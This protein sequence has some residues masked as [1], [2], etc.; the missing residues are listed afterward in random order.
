M[1]VNFENLESKIQIEIHCKSNIQI[2][3]IDPEVL[4]PP[5]NDEEYQV[6]Y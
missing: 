5:D 1:Q 6:S 4:C 3:Q 2:F